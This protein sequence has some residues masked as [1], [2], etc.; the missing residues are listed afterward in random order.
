MEREKYILQLREMADFLESH[1]GLPIPIILYN[2]GNATSIV[3]SKDEFAAIARL[4]PKAEKS[5]KDGYFNLKCEFPSGLVYQISAQHNLICKRVVIGKETVEEKVPVTF[6]TKTVVREIVEWR[7]PD[8][9]L[10][11]GGQ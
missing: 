1:P 2:W 8:S 9:L 3:Y 11:E 10:A 4:L 5:S 7:C 6:E